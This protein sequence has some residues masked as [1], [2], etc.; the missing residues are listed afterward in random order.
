MVK[1]TLTFLNILSHRF[2]YYTFGL[3]LYKA[4]PEE[5]W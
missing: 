2:M 1:Q 4:Q 3:D 5:Y